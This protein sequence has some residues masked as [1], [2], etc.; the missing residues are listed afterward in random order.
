[1]KIEMGKKYRFN[2]SDGMKEMRSVRRVV[3]VDMLGM[4]PVLVEL[5]DGSTER[6]SAEGAEFKHKTSYD[7]S[8]NDLIEVQENEK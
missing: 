7:N 4:Y 3:A 8:E 1:M 2:S 6:F 5:N